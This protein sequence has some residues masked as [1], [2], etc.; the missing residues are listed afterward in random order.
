MGDFQRVS[1]TLVE[2]DGKTGLV[3]DAEQRDIGTN[4]LRCSACFR[5]QHER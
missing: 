3:V 2:E 4:T 1:Y 5:R